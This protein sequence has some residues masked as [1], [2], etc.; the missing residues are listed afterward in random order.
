[1]LPVPEIVS[2]KR[3]R[4]VPPQ[5]SGEIPIEAPL[6]SRRPA[7]GSRRSEPPARSAPRAAG[8]P[9]RLRLNEAISGGSLD[10]VILS[11]L[12]DDLKPPK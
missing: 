5:K 7:P 3:G 11:Y 9:D 10:E 4:S 8:A 12:A 1:V 2:K 6:Q